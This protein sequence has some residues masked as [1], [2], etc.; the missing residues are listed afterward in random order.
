MKQ[1][2]SLEGMNIRPLIKTDKASHKDN[3]I[4]YHQ[5]G[6]AGVELTTF[7]KELDERWQYADEMIR[8]N[9]G[10]KTREA[11]ANILMQK[12]GISRATAYSDIVNAEEVHSSSK[13][14]NKRYRIGLRIEK[15]EAAIHDAMSAKEPDYRGIAAMEKVLAGYINSYPDYAP[16][17][18]P[19][20]II[21]NVTNQTQ[22]N[23]TMSVEEAEAKADELIHKLKM[24]GDFE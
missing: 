3:I 14:L 6:G 7:E 23:F 20:T 11:I 13:P 10:K 18:S 5:A 24:E 17:V 21:F 15:L 9:V 12:F 22:N 16:S 8:R 1:D 4:R 19:K 2:E